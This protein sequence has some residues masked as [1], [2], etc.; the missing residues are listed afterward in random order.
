MTNWQLK[1]GEVSDGQTKCTKVVGR[2]VSRS[3]YANDRY[4][5]HSTISC[6]D[7]LTLDLWVGLCQFVCICAYVCVEY[8]IK[9]TEYMYCELH[10]HTDIHIHMHIYRRIC[11]YLYKVCMCRCLSASQL[12]RNR[13][14]IALVYFCIWICIVNHTCRNILITASHR[15]FWFDRALACV[16]VATSKYFIA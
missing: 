15:L 1:S 14:L 9:S 2:T 12:M 7:K 11:I 3:S 5:N 10:M 4:N 13:L 6:E 16:S 8:N